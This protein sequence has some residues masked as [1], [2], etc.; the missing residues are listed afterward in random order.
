V[1]VWAASRSCQTMAS[2][3]VSVAVG[4]V[5]RV[6]E[7]VVWW[8]SLKGG[9]GVVGRAGYCV[10]VLMVVVWTGVELQPRRK[11]IAVT[12]E[13]NV[14]LRREATSETKRRLYWI[15]GTIV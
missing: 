11:I 5:T 3:W 7:S 4:V 8:K 2:I 10:E 14:T 1:W 13:A 12:A 15:I 9:G 6:K